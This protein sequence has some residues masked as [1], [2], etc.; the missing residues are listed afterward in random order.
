[1]AGMYGADT[2]QLRR[3]ARAFAG[4]AD[5]IDSAR[6]SCDTSVAHVEWVGADADRFRGSW[7]TI[8]AT[9]LAS[10]T[11]LLHDVAARLDEQAAQQDHASD[12]ADAAGGHGPSVHGSSDEP[13]WK[14][15]IRSIAPGTLG[16][17]EDFLAEG[18]VD[19]AS[20]VFEGWDWSVFSSAG[21]SWGT[22]GYA[23]IDAQPGNYNEA[24]R[25]R[26]AGEPGW[27]TK[28]RTFR[29][30]DGLKP[31]EGVGVFRFGLSGSATL[32]GASA[33]RTFDVPLIGPVN[34]DVTPTVGANARLNVLELKY[35]DR[36]ADDG[37]ATYGVRTG[38]GGFAGVRVPI[39]VST[40]LFDGFVK[41][42][43][44]ASGTLGAS[45]DANIYGEFKDG[46]LSFGARAGAGLGLGGSLRAG[47]SI[48]FNRTP[49]FLRSLVP[50]F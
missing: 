37:G 4:R 34:V 45:A 19:Y 12:G 31:D 50:D 16:F 35:G 30:S 25:F 18:H 22:S 10:M 46:V 11:S 24:R 32:L 49:E 29:D 33:N 42:Y 41:P 27:Q 8:A 26:T 9:R 48:D 36:F 17:V 28:T 21:A 5:A 7:E 2:P 40:E 47:A 1:M 23:G 15:A 3:I 43:A 14:Q 44:S 38:V 6:A 13:W 39:T 20:G